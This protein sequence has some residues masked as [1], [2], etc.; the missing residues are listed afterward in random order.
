MTAFQN[1]PSIE[2]RELHRPA[3]ALSG[4]EL[5]TVNGGK[6]TM[7]GALFADAIR[8]HDEMLSSIARNI[9]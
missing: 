9:R 5:D 2:W 6:F 7:L 1:E 3:Q 4:A 8:K